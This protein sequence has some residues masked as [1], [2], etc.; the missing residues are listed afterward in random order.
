MA[1]IVAV[2]ALGMISAL[3]RARAQEVPKG[4]KSG[5]VMATDGAKIHYVD[6]APGEKM[7][8]SH[9][10]GMSASGCHMGSPGGDAKGCCA[11]GCKCGG[12]EETSGESQ[13]GSRGAGVQCQDNSDSGAN[14]GDHAAHMTPEQAGHASMSHDPMGAANAP[15]ILLVP[16]W[17]MPWWIWQKQVDYFSP[18]YRVVAMDPRCQGQSSQTTDGLYPAQMAHDIKSVIDQGRLAPV[19]LVGWSMAVAE[20]GAYVDQFGTNDLAGIVLVDGG[21]GDAG[22]PGLDEDFA[23]LKQVLTMSR[24]EQA[25]VFVRNLCF[26]R[27]H[28]EDYVG[29]VIEASASVPGNSAVALLAGYDSANYWPALAKFDKPTLVIGANTQWKGDLI[30][31]HNKIAGSRI[32][33]L[34]NVGHAIFVD[35][36]EEFNAKVDEFIASIKP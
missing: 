13:Q 33:L 32:E 20:V 14:G 17:T 5:F 11:G 30:E 6:M 21:M 35:D 29:R 26:K 19:V 2:L 23:I 1:S 27:A 22:R 28:P 3:P 36:P 16:G 9:S 12:N 31:E 18:K 34:D 8:G 15:T 10:G 7:G 4:A 25:S 24:P